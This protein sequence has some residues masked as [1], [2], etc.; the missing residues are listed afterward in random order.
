MG[1]SG[2]KFMV[3]IVLALG[4][5]NFILIVVAIVFMATINV[6]TKRQQDNITF[7]FRR[8]KEQQRRQEQREEQLLQSPK[9]P[10]HRRKVGSQHE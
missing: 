3:E 6:R 7:L 1:I 4:V 8:G 5:A 9:Q 10:A 2:V